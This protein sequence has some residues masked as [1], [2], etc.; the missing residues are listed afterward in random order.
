MDGPHFNVRRRS[1]KWRQFGVLGFLA[2]LTFGPFV[3]IVYLDAKDGTLRDTC[4][5]GLRGICTMFGSAGLRFY[6]SI[7]PPPPEPESSGWCCV[8]L[9]GGPDLFQVDPNT[10]RATASA[11]RFDDG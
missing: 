3:W 8:V 2:A 11:Q 1:K 5:G 9:G 6:H 10:R 7:D 4:L